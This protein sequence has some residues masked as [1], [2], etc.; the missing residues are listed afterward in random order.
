MHILPD[1]IDNR[2]DAAGRDISELE[3]LANEVIHGE[4]QIFKNNRT[5]VCWEII[6]DSQT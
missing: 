2:L 1:E 3:D 4:A 6:S 5:L